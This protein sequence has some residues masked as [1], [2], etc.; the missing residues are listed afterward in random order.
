MAVVNGDFETGDLTGWSTVVVDSDDT[1]DTGQVT[2]NAQSYEGDWCAYIEA[3]RMGLGNAASVTFKQD[4]DLTKALTLNFA[5]TPY[6]MVNGWFNVYVDGDLKLS[7]NNDGLDYILEELDISGYTGIK[8]VEF[9]AQTGS[10]MTAVGI[11]LD[12]VV[13][14]YVPNPKRWVHHGGMKG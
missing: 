2:I 3:V 7:I 11:L 9:V 4:I 6:N 10:Q 5:Y 8:T 1:L 13:V 14:V 12:Q